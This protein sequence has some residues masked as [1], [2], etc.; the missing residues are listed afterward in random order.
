MNIQ[1]KGSVLGLA[2]AVQQHVLVKT[3][4]TVVKST[5]CKV[6]APVS[7]FRKQFS[8]YSNRILLFLIGIKFVILSFDLSSST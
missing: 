1:S 6:G 8:L 5:T 3:G 4:S 2:L 7:L